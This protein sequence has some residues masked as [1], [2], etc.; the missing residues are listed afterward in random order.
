M[1][2]LKLG[3]TDIEISQMGIGHCD[4]GTKIPKDTAFQVLDAYYDAGGNFIDTS[5]NYCIWLPG[6][7]GGECETIIGEWMKNRR[8]RD[9]IV[10]STKLGA[11]VEDLSSIRNSDGSLMSDWYLR[12]E[13]LSKKAIIAA[14]EGSLKRLQTDHIDLYY[15]HVEDAEIDPQETLEAFD[16]LE[17]QGKIRAIGCSNHRT[18][19]IERAKQISQ[20]NN[21]IEYCCTQDLHTYLQPDP[22]K[23]ALFATQEKLDYLRH[24]PEVALIA[25]TPTLWGK[26]AQ[27]EKYEDPSF[28][29]EFYGPTTAAKL[30]ALREIAAKHNASEIQIVYAW[31][32][33]NSPPAV[34][35]IA[36]SSVQHL[37]EN[38]AACKISLSDGD[39]NILNKA[40][41]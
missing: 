13:G 38:L 27:T 26:Y 20:K 7:K 14:I 40:N 25:Y 6:G 2:K 18:W 17:K 33:Q 9:H 11:N 12:G 10:L 37:L 8:N 5:N 29:D 36:T 39:L 23:R 15:A 1:K 16:Q 19:R 31:M 21:L 24:N 35:L 32:M 28:W 4:F 3:H 34:P 30:N 41:N 22:M